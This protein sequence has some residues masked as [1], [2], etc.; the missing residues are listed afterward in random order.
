MDRIFRRKIITFFSFSSDYIFYLIFFKKPIKHK[1][2]R[3][4]DT[5]DVRGT[6]D[7]GHIRVMR[8]LY[9]GST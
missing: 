1:G 6:D 9:Q 5:G 8:L 2:V 7:I 3:Y 4:G